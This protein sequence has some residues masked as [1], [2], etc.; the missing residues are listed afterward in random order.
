MLHVYIFVLE[1]LQW[2]APRTRA[3]FGT[4]LEEAE[5]TKL[6]AFNQG[7]YNLFL[8]IVTGG[9][10]RVHDLGRYPGRRGPGLRRCG[11]DVGGRGG[12]AGVVAGQGALRG[13]PGSVSVGGRRPARDRVVDVGLL[14]AARDVDLVATGALGQVHGPVGRFHQIL[15]Q[16][17][18][19]GCGYPCQGRGG[20]AD[21][22]GDVPR[23]RGDLA[24]QSFGHPDRGLFGADHGDDELLAADPGGDRVTAARAPQ[25][26]CDLDQRLVAC[27]V[28]RGVVDAFE[29]VQVDHQDRQDGRAVAD[30]LRRQGADRSVE[31]AAVRQ[32]GQRIGV[33]LERVGT[34]DVHQHLCGERHGKH[35]HEQDQK[36]A[37]GEGYADVLAVLNR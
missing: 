3:T 35:A 36:F 37:H 18:H 21:A 30:R 7:F 15:N 27:R 16:G 34:E 31:G 5:A 6:L 26:A 28:S 20:H 9:G 13:G 2:T 12:A 17:L 4:T 32:F 8:A 23:R 14:G 10:R 25:N 22:G 1:S 19:A 11:L 29:G 24:T 33:G